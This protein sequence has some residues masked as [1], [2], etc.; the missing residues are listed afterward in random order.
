MLISEAFHEMVGDDPTGF[1]VV[2]YIHVET[3]TDAHRILS[4]GWSLTQYISQHGDVEVEFD[5][6]YRVYRV[7]SF[8]E[9]IA[10]FKTAKAADCAR[11]GCE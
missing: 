7:P 2:E 9:E 5:E 11:W 4:D 8:A 3:K 10:S 1:N 6:Q